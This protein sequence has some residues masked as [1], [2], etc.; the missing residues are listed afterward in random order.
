MLESRRVPPA[1]R[2]TRSNVRDAVDRLRASLRTRLSRAHPDVIAAAVLPLVLAA[3]LLAFRPWAPTLD[4]AMTE[5]RVRD[6]GG[7]HTPLIGLPGRIGDFPAQGSHPGPLSFYL[8][9]PFYRLAGASPWG[10]EL[11]SVVIN[12]IAVA[13][14]VLIGA[15]LAGRRGA[16]AMAALAAVAIRGYGLNVLTHP[17]N[18]YLPV[19]VWLLALVAAWAVL[20]GDHWSAIVVIVAGTLAAQTHIPYLLNAIA[21]TFVVLLVMLWRRLDAPPDRRA[22][23]SRPMW[24]SIGVGAVLWVPPFV[25]QAIRDPGNIRMLIR[26]FRRGATDEEPYI[27]LG[28]A[29]RAFFRHLDAFGAAVDLVTN[30]AAFVHRSGLPSGNGVGGMVVFVLWLGACWVAWRRHHLRLRALN[31]VVAVALVVMAFSIS[32]IFGKLWYYLTLWAWSAMLL[33]VVSIGW[34]ILLE[35]AARRERRAVERAVWPVAALGLAATAAS[36]GAAF[37]LD[38]PE[39]QMSDGLRA[40]IPATVDAIE[41]GDGL[42]AGPDGRYLVF[43]QDASYIGA[44]GYGLV[45]ELDRRGYDVGV[46]DTWRVPVTQQRVMQ[47]GTYDAEIHLVSGMF[48]DQW[49]ARPDHVEIIEV[50]PRT[51][52]EKARFEELH[53]RVDERLR[54]LG[55]DDLLGEVEC[56][57]FGASLDQA[58]PQ[59]VIDDLS[60]ML[61]LSQPIAIFIA[62]PGSPDG[63]C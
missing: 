25:D 43:W 41:R 6:V 13:G 19:L 63:R 8:L 24:W 46:G 18:P 52:E 22:E 27:S 30:K 49:N 28:T 50:D 54:E 44:Q 60:E 42:L 39:A 11:G 1:G 62:P 4:M 5:L 38:V 10:M 23:V 9:A 59:D 45:N 40:V 29:V 35:V 31:G 20:A 26:H 3:L 58:L 48:I 16:I 55:R 36:V 61:L 33:A 7:P 37:V 51:T 14:I 21:L 34:A 32:R 17:W 53:T 57:L 47:P 15:R 2:G 12:V 56:N